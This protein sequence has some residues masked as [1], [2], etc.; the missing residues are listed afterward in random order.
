MANLAP[1]TGPGA[2]LPMDSEVLQM[3][4]AIA[5]K[6]PTQGCS[7]EHPVLYSRCLPSSTAVSSC[8]SSQNRRQ[9]LLLPPDG[10]IRDTRSPSQGFL[11]MLCIQV[12][13][14]S[15]LGPHLRDFRGAG[16][17]RPEAHSSSTAAPPSRSGSPRARRCGLEGAR[18]GGDPSAGTWRRLASRDKSRC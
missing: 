12:E 4:D 5:L 8:A 9:L 18:A 10:P 7:S 13:E 6:H 2:G 16:A 11:A 15:F 1:I 3:V 14:H 17:G